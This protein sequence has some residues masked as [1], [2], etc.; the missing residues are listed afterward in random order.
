MSGINIRG[1]LFPRSF[2]LLLSAHGGERYF[3]TSWRETVSDEHGVGGG[4]QKATATQQGDHVMMIMMMMM[5]SKKSVQQSL[6]AWPY[7][8]ECRGHN[9]AKK[10]VTTEVACSVGKFCTYT[11]LMTVCS[12]SN[13]EKT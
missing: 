5:N 4:S 2:L 13:M 8:R 1:P 11:L 10:S 3:S 7:R 6:E 9:P 12:T